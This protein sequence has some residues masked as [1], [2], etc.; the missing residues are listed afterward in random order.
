M[1]ALA[2]K[3]ALPLPDD[4]INHDEELR[5]GFILDALYRRVLADTHLLVAAALDLDPATFRLPDSAT[6]ELLNEAAAR[7]VLISATTRQAIAAK[8]QEGQDAGLSTR[9]IAQSIEHLFTVTWAGRAEMVARTEIA[10]AQVKSAVDRYRASGL[11]D[12]V[13]I[14]DGEDDEPC[15]SRNGTT[16]PLDEAPGLAHPRCT[17]LL[18][19][20]LK[21]EA[22]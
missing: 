22:G 10:H 11:V 8:L 17:L 18:I 16:V 20:V 1:S 19:P 7:V 12:R 15:R 9:E 14:I 2:R 6:T 21:D 13:H 5:L 4:L 3:A